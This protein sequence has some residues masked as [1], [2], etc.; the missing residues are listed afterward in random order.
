MQPL[1]VSLCEGLGPEDLPAAMAGLLAE[2]PHVRGAA[3][4]ALGHIPF[5][6]DGAPACWCGKARRNHTFVQLAARVSRGCCA[7][8]VLASPDVAALLWLARH[9]MDA[10]NLHAG[11]QLW[12]QLGAQL[13]PDYVAPVLTHLRHVHVGVRSAAAAALAEG[14][15]V[16][17]D[18]QQSLL[19]RRCS[20]CRLV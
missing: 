9:D 20:C 18:Q 3:I 12:D 14:M 2:A 15:Q 5:L 10:A 16:R 4:A 8:D 13:N 6:S 1:L 11:Q 7:G 17:D 19:L